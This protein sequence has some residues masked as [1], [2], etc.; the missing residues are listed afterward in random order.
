MYKRFFHKKCLICFLI[1]VRRTLFPQ[2]S[3]QHLIYRATQTFSIVLF[4]SF[5]F[6]KT[7]VAQETVLQRVADYLSPLQILH[8]KS[9]KIRPYNII[10]IKTAGQ[11]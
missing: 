2:T 1:P 9:F 7:T 10:S 11:N 8:P 4:S 3:A 5:V 6:L